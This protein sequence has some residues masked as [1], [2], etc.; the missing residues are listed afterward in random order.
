MTRYEAIR[1]CESLMCRNGIKGWQCRINFRLRRCLGR[2]DYHSQVIH[3][4]G[5]LIDHNS[6]AKIID[7]IKH[8]VAHI[9]A[10]GDG[11][12]PL[13][14]AACQRLGA[15]CQ[16]KCDETLVN[17]PPFKPYAAQCPH[18]KRVY[19]RATTQYLLV[20]Q[21]EGNKD[22]DILVWYHVGDQ[23][24]PK[25]VIFPKV[26]G[27]PLQRVAYQLYQKSCTVDDLLLKLSRCDDLRTKKQLR[28]RIRKLGHYGGLKSRR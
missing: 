20:C 17:R 16:A 21:C 27:K 22:K 15:D 8:E 23:I 19:T 6:H 2:C 1:Y 3:L 12:G 5:W 25:G 4:A 18:C 26:E 11:H 13:W 9:L 10:P 24:I 28:N 14:R 7:T